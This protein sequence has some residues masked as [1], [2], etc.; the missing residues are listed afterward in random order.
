MSRST[1]ADWTVV[2]PMMGSIS[3]PEGESHAPLPVAVIRGLSMRRLST[4]AS[5]FAILAT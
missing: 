4:W 3:L 5:R 1:R 2:L